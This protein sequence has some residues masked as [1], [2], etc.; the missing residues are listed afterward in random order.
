[1]ARECFVNLGVFSKTHRKILC[2][3]HESGWS[4]CSD[5]HEQ[6]RPNFFHN[7]ACLISYVN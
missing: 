3:P 2:F 6:V 7:C 1:M 4:L 5:I